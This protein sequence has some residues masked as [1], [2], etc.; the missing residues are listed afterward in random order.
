MTTAYVPH[1]ESVPGARQP[2]PRRIAAWL[3]THET[4]IAQ[5]MAAAARGATDAGDQDDAIAQ[6]CSQSLRYLVWWWR[7]GDARYAELYLG[8]R[9]LTLVRPDN[10]GADFAL[11][12]RQA[13]VAADRHWLQQQAPA[14]LATADRQLLLERWQQLNAALVLP[15]HAAVD[16]LFVGDCLSE[17][18]RSFLRAACLRDG[19]WLQEHLVWRHDG[20]SQR[21]E[22]AALADQPLRLVFF[23]PVSYTRNP[24][25]SDLRRWQFAALPG[26]AIRRR[27]DAALEETAHILDVLANVFECPVYVHDTVNVRF[28]DRRGVAARLL[29]LV[30]ARTRRLAR[31]H[32]G[33]RLREFLA[34]R[35]AATFEHLFLLEEAALL[36]QHGDARLSGYFYDEPQRHPIGLLGA[37]LAPQYADALAVQANLA[38]RKLVVCDLDNTLWDGVIGEGD[39]RHHHDRQQALLALKAKGVV[40]AVNSKNDP[41]R[42]HWTGGRLGADDFVH[43]EIS[44]NPKVA[45][46]ERIR[47]ALNLKVK[48]FV[49]ID[50]RADER[51]LMAAA[52]PQVAVL[53]ATDARTWQ[54]LARWARV[55]PPSEMDRT[56][57]YRSRGAREQALAEVAAQAVDEAQMFGQLELRATIRGARAAD[58][59]RATELINRTN[60]FNM[61]G[62]RTTLR[63]M[64]AWFEAPGRHVLLVDAADRFGD[65]GTVSVALVQELPDQVEIP[66]FV[67]SCRVFGYRIEDVVLTAAAGLAQ[68]RNR[69][70]VGH[71][72][73]TAHNAPC[74]NVYPDH[75]FTWTGAQW[76]RPP[77]PL[78][79]L[80]AWL[81]VDAQALAFALDGGAAAPP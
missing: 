3:D 18:I 39:V 64:R 21:K 2:S 34:Q 41:A 42:V 57:F 70:L 58:L 53:D 15:I 62:S 40:L 80:P 69:A 63:E 5:A 26:G 32:I 56:S 4:L 65:M 67:L 27:V 52:F 43:M 68:A 55:L 61:C 1:P 30:T 50:D 60:Q 74:R 36:R 11:A 75:G 76:H 79:P 71:Y 46:M 35:N 66:V 51:A 28:G 31:A 29:R 33:R 48:D 77:A 54:R 44:W 78:R 38:G 8:A 14:D 24:A 45:G 19:L 49:F 37:L 17:D 7:S 12:A 6:E 72:R 9:L 16:V 23:S 47:D 22:I 59:A 73:E 13:A 10:R 81:A 20:A 25:L